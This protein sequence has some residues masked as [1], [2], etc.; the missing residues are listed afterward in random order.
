MAKHNRVPAWDGAPAA[1]QEYEYEVS[2]FETSLSTKERPQLVA[3]LYPF[4]SGPGK[5][6][7]QSEPATRF[8]G[9]SA[10]EYLSYLRIKVGILPIPDLGNRLDDFF[11]RLF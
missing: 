4:L 1:W 3:K 9:W 10:E 6:A 11:F 8:T 2:W 7:M 5:K